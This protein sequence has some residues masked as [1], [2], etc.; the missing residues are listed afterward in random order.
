MLGLARTGSH[1]DSDSSDLHV[2]PA[3]TVAE[4]VTNSRLRLR[5]RGEER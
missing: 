5:D 2:A 3:H 4:P 1:A